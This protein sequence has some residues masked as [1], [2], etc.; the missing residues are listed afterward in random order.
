MKRWHLIAAWIVGGY[1]LDVLLRTKVAE[2]SARAYCDSVGKPLLNVGSGTRT[3]SLAAFLMGPSRV[4][5]VN[6]D[7]AATAECRVERGS[8][9]CHGD[10]HDLSRWPDKFFGAVVGCHV[11]EHL[12]DPVRAIQEWRRVADRV[13]VVTP[14]P[15]TFHAYAHPGH[16]WLAAG[17]PER[18]TPLWPART[19]EGFSGQ[20]TGSAWWPSALTPGW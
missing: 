7:I 11:A 14:S 6:L 10:A 18:W 1:V 9:P 3:S 15:L 16:R 20:P 8:E 19:H 13:Y 2:R 4:G 12:D 5:D 17:P